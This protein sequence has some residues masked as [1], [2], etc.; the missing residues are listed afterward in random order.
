MIRNLSKRTLLTAGSIIGVAL[1]A[2]CGYK[3]ITKAKNDYSTLKKENASSSKIFKT[4]AID[5]LPLTASFIAT[6]TMIAANHV[7]ANKEINDLSQKLT[8]LG[9]AYAVTVTQLDKAKHNAEEIVGKEKTEEIAKKT[10]ED[11]NS[12]KVVSRKPDSNTM[13]TGYFESDPA[14]SEC[15]RVTNTG[16][17]DQLIQT[18]Y[19]GHYFRSS[20]LRVELQI[21]DLLDEIKNGHWPYNWVTMA[22]VCEAI[23]VKPNEGDRLLAVVAADEIVD[24]CDSIGVNW[25]STI[26]PNNEAILVMGLDNEIYGISTNPRRYDRY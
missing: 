21:R 18:E 11:I 6:T 1:T 20:P 10:I 2:Y 26:G 12:S 16:N 23:G 8:Q 24:G 3:C 5:T 4:I 25:K 15:V 7:E 13:E 9:S 17:G 14:V 22:D 19:G